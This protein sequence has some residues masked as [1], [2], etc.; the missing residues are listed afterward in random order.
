MQLVAAPAELL[1]L[2]VFLGAPVAAPWQVGEILHQTAFELPL[3]TCGLGRNRVWSLLCRRHG[4]SVFF[5]GM[6]ACVDGGGITADVPDEFVT[7]VL[8]NH[9]RVDDLRQSI[10]GKDGEGPGEGR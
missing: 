5:G 4:L 1:A 9:G 6:F 7:Q 10:R 8:L 2:A 3:Q